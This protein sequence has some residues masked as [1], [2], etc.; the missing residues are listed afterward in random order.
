[1]ATQ[2]RSKE[3][4]LIPK[5]VNLHQTICLIDGIIER[6]YDKTSWNPNKQNNL[7]VNL[8][9]WG[10]TRSGKNIS[11]QAIRT[12][13]AS[14]PQYLGFVYV[15]TN[16]TPN[17]ICI[18]NAGYQLWNNHKK[19]LVKITNLTEAEGKTVDTSEL[20]LA[21]MEKLQITNPIILK[22]CENILVFPFRVTLAL[23]R[24]LNYLDIEELAY[25]VFKMRDN[26]EINLTISEINNF[27]KL[28]T[29]ERKKIIDEFK[30][31]HIGNITLV[32]AASSKYYQSLCKMTGIIDN[33]RIKPQNSDSPL[34]S[35]RIN[36]KYINYVDEI[37]DEKYININ[38]YDFKDNLSLWMDYIGEPS[39]LS[40][41]IEISLI[42]DSNADIF[43]L[44]RK[45][46]EILDGDIIEKNS[47][48]SLPMFPNE[49]YYAEITDINNGKK[50]A[51]NT[52]VPSLSKTN[53]TLSFETQLE[54]TSEE[55]FDNLCEEILLH[56]E[57]PNFCGKMENYLKIL[58]K[59]TGINKIEDKSL[60]G[61][62]YEYLFF[63]L[64]NLLKDSKKIDEV[65]WNGRI[66]KYN[67]PTSAPG[68]KTGTSDIIFTIDDT[69]YVL[70]L[71]TIKS[72]S[73]QFSAE[74][75]SV[76]DHIRLYSKTTNNK[77]VG[78]FVAPIIH[79]RNT[80]TMKSVLSHSNIN[81]LCI[82]DNDFIKILNSD[83]IKNEL[84]KLL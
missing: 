44:I 51:V 58:S 63:K 82:N 47:N 6:K 68:G 65:V 39:R 53:Y 9:N 60:R 32:Q 75:S 3:V 25:F 5:R 22:D 20:V 52:I 81:I 26:S 27:R 35:I 64:L 73:M 16:T 19:E 56:S 40:P 59:I 29:I 1:M 71:T 43:V 41:P 67:L 76:P 7:G 66:G 79:E 70:E 17:T 30:K 12:L 38:T 42:N 36:E 83:N 54:E 69:D 18:T 84:E 49:E 10:A 34:S 62:Y 11:P 46:D 4:W 80:N 48:L 21:Q 13:M 72:K 45:D 14:V 15:N 74:C 55:N 78:I 77:V 57:A 50:I 23:L 61:A 24:E 8:K 33:I 31:T 28:S 2:N 37:L